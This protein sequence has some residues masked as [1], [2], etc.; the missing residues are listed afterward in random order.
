MIIIFD[1]DDTLYP[2]LSYVHSGFRVV[3]EAVTARLGGDPE[4]AMSLMLDSLA[5]NRRGRQFDDLAAAFG[6]SGKSIVQWMV[7]IYRHHIPD[8]NLPALSDEVLRACGGASLYLVTDGHKVVQSQKISTLGLWDRF[9]HCYLTNRYGTRYQKPSPYVFELILKR[10]GAKARD[11]VYIGDNPLKDFCGIRPLGFR[12]MRVCQGKYCEV[13]VPAERD[14]EVSINNLDELL[15]VL[16][17]W[18]WQL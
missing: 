16:K 15:P 8:I 17:G 5:Q 1:L 2:E 13:S 3:A 7:K 6:V 11:A 9:R 10:E 14:A 12:T 18:G 4:W